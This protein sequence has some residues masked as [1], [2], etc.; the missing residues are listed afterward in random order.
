MKKPLHRIITIL[1]MLSIG[2]GAMWSFFFDVEQF[3]CEVTAHRNIAAKEELQ[4]I[5]L[6]LKDFSHR[7][8]NDEVWVHGMLYDVSSYIIL[9]D[10]ACVWVFHDQQEERIV[11][12]IIGNFSQNDQYA[13]DNVRHIS[14][15]HNPVPDSKI[16]VTPYVMRVINRPTGHYSISG[17]VEYSSREYSGVI[18]PPPRYIIA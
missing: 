16:L 5:K 15:H 6:P 7:A 11:N 2:M 12:T 1:L 3:R 17:C 9:N 8:E 13:S 14:K 4:L 18:K 10:S